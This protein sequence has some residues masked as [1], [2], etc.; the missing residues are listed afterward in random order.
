[1]KKI[2]RRQISYRGAIV[3]EISLLH[4]ESEDK[5]V[6]IASICYNKKIP[7]I[8]K[9]Q[10]IQRLYKEHAGNPTSSFE[11]VNF[12]F[13]VKCP[14]FVARQWMRHRIGSYQEVSRRYYKGEPE[15]YTPRQLLDDKE[16]KQFLDKS[17]EL[18]LSYIQNGI[19]SEVARC[20]LPLSTFTEFFWQVNLRSLINFLKVR[21]SPH[22]QVEIR[23]FADTILELITPYCPVVVELI[24]R[25][26]NGSGE[27]STPVKKQ[28]PVNGVATTHKI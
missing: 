21:L 19:P 7:E 9:K 24:K 28:L 1:M 14:I 11:F 18:Y 17:K 23:C 13:K 6:E 25:D 20:V 4:A 16:Y 5:I 10:L 26:L 2:T 8:R 22:A 27:G 15:F 3:G 12:L